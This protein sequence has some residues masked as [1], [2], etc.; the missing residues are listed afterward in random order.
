VNASRK[1]R[2]TIVG[3]Y[4]WGKFWSISEGSGSP[5][6]YLSPRG[7]VD[8]GHRIILVTPRFERPAGREVVDGIEIVRYAGG[9]GCVT[10]PPGGPALRFLR[11][12]ANYVH[13]QIA[14]FVAAF[15]V[16]RRIRPDALIAYGEYS[17]PVTWLLGKC[18][19][20]PTVARLFGTGIAPF[21][22]RPLHLAYHFVQVL[23]FGVPATRTILCDDGSKG[24]VV[25]RRL[26]V[27]SDRLR[28][29]RN[30]ADHAL[31]RP[32]ADRRALRR[33]LDL[34]P[35]DVLLFTVSRL[36]GQK[37]ID[38]ILAALP[39]V[40]ASHPTTSL[41]IVGDGAERAALEAEAK[42]LGVADAVFFAGAVPRERLGDFINAGD[43]FVAMSDRTNAAN[44]LFEAML[45]AKPCV[46]LNTGGT[47]EVIEDGVNGWLVPESRPEELAPILVRVLSDGPRALAVGKRALEWAK[48]NIPTYEERQRLEVSVVEEVVRAPRGQ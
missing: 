19:R 6:F 39:Q 28:F 29:W 16:C 10:E 43:V 7:F 42:R 15:R 11:R 18:F 35:D 34:P 23:A 27:S 5:S 20:V 46:V 26:G 2:F 9:P 17:T 25:A 44:P 3:L 37:R 36:W 21:L 22:G 41:L 31:Y 32:A 38:R 30:G 8:A 47:A 1:E 4:P 48:A 24:D 14:A 12:T 33:E 40:R 45:C 13:Y